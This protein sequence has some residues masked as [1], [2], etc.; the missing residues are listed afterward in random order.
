RVSAPVLEA[1]AVEVRY[2]GRLVLD[3]PA[4]SVEPGEVLAVIGPNGAGKSTLLH[5]LALLARPTRGTVRLHGAAPRTETERLAW[6]RRGGCV[7]QDAL[8]FRGSVP[9]KPPLP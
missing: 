5:V 8:P 7:F 2:D 6:R 4:L 1:E 3:V 9:Y